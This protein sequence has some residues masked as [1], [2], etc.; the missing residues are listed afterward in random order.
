MLR[1]LVL[2]LLVANLVFYGWSSGW[3]DAVVGIP[4]HGDREPERPA[5][6]VR[7]ENVV[8]LSS[9]ASATATVATR[10][11]EAGPF[12]AAEAA[13]VA[14][15]LRQSI[16]DLAWRDVALE[17]PGVWT[18][19]LG[20]FPSRDAMLP[21]E[22]ELRRIGIDYAETTVPGESEAGLALGRHEDRGEAE[23][24]LAALQQRGIRGGRVLALAGASTQH[25]L[26]IEAAPP[27]TVTRLAALKLEPSGFS[28]CAA[29]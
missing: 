9:E 21:K 3:L 18:V 15:A 1:A 29:R 13:S 2:A 19:Y 11:I 4:A 5:R 6:Q 25:L 16:P 10:C 23:K 12:A 8:I 26:R 17:R 27:E 22:D 28:P 14:A 20:G 24:A 7:P